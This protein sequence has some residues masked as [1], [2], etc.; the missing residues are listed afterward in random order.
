MGRNPKMSVLIVLAI[1]SLI[2]GLSAMTKI[3]ANSP[4]TPNPNQPPTGAD[5]LAAIASNGITDNNPGN[6]EDRDPPIAWQG[7][8]GYNILVIR[9]V[10]RRF[11]T[12][13]SLLNGVRAAMIN[14]LSIWQE[15]AL[16]GSLSLSDFGEIWA[17][18]P[19]NPG[20]IL[21]DYGR[22][23]ANYLSVSPIE[24]F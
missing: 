3:P 24:P 13:D 2:G 19:D 15:H 4:I 20:A 9:G 16:Q 12:F 21:G 11:T 14:S 8:T 18:T 6:L 5:V 10:S 22:R 17:P 7:R 1:L 23:I